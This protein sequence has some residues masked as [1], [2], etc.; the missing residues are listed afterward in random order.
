MTLYRRM[1][2]DLLAV[3][4][5]D[6]AA[7][8]NAV[9]ARWAADPTDRYAAGALACGQWIAGLTDY[10]PLRDARRPCSVE[11]MTACQ[12][13]ADAVLYGWAWAPRGVDIRWALGVAAMVSWARGAS[14]R[15]PVELAG[16][17]ASA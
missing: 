10:H 13:A 6:F 12:L 7:A 11:A 5:A 1:P 14:R 17:V 8:L 16:G 3:P 4:A 15:P 2:A 9:G